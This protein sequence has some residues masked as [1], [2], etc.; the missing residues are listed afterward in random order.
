MFERVVN[1]VFFFLALTLLAAIG[2]ML[3]SYSEKQRVNL[4]RSGVVLPIG[5]VSRIEFRQVPQ[6]QLVARDTEDPN[7]VRMREMDVALARIVTRRG[8]GRIKPLVI[9]LPDTD[10]KI[11]DT[12]PVTYALPL[13]ET[14]T[15]NISGLP[16]YYLTVR[17]TRPTVCMAVKAPYTWQS[18]EPALQKLKNWMKQNNTVPTGRPRILLYNLQ[19][20][21][22]EDWKEFEVQIPVR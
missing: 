17:E 12:R 6:F 13:P 5:S 18:F 2:Y 16:D 7:L 19:S 21:V 8:F 3:V 14:Q 11:G 10:W 22:P 9:E 4:E 20:F 1:W 15:I